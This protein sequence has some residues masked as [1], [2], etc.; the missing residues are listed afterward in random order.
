VRPLSKYKSER[1]EK[2]LEDL[3]AKFQDLGLISWGTTV[4]VSS[5]TYRVIMVD[6]D[7]KLVTS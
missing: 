7:G 3:L 6:D 1:E 2:L 4:K 5:G